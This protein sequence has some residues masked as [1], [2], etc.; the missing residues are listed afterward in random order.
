MKMSV[1]I[2]QQGPTANL[3]STSFELTNTSNTEDSTYT[4]K[5]IV[6][7]SDGC[8]HK[9]TSLQLLFIPYLLLIL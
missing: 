8:I 9:D 4:I 7:D 1:V 2:Y 6:G 5:L 3:V